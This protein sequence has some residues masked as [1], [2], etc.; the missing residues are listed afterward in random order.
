MGVDYWILQDFVDEGLEITHSFGMGFQTGGFGADE[1][2]K[3][4]LPSTSN[5]AP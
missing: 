5:I 4:G 1:A 2:W 3:S